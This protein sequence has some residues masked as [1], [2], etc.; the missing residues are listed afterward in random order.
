MWRG[1]VV[2][3]ATRVWSRSGGGGGWKRRQGGGGS[4]C[5][6]RGRGGRL[7]GREVELCHYRKQRKTSG[8]SDPLTCTQK[9]YNTLSE[10]SDSLPVTKAAFTREF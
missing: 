5:R 4:G 6:G 1:G 10:A 7:F 2:I 8:V 3:V 9:P